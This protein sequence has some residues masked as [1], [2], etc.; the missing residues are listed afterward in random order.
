MK[1]DK[2]LIASD[3]DGTLKNDDGII[4]DDVINAIK[5]FL[6]ILLLIKKTLFISTYYFYLQIKFLFL[7]IVK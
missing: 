1:F 5:Y 3:F 7:T 6:H 2:V 4:T